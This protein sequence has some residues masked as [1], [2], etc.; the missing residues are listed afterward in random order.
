MANADEDNQDDI[1]YAEYNNDD[2]YVNNNNNN[3]DDYNSNSHHYY[4]YTNK[5]NNHY[6]YTVK[7]A[8]LG[9]PFYSFQD[10]LPEFEGYEPATR[11]PGPGA[12]YVTIA[13][14]IALVALVPFCMAIR[15]RF[16][17]RRRPRRRLR[18]FSKGSGGG[19]KGSST[20]FR[21]TVTSPT[22][23]TPPQSQSTDGI[24]KNSSGLFV[25]DGA[26]TCSE[27][28]H[29]KTNEK[30]DDAATIEDD[31]VQDEFEVEIDD[32]TTIIMDDDD[33][34]AYSLTKEDRMGS[35]K[36]ASLSASHALQFLWWLQWKPK[37]NRQN[38]VQRA[39]QVVRSFAHPPSPPRT[40]PSSSKQKFSPPSEISQSPSGGSMSSR[41]VGIIQLPKLYD[42]DDDESDDKD[43]KIYAY[44]GS[45][46]DWE[47]EAN[48]EALSP[49]SSIV[50]FDRVQ[51][52]SSLVS[53]SV[54]SSRRP[55]T[56]DELKRNETGVSSNSP[57]SHRLHR[58]A[59][60][61]DCNVQHIG[62][63]VGGT[64]HGH[65]V[66]N[67]SQEQLQL[68]LQRIGS[69]SNIRGVSCVS[70]TASAAAAAA[71]AD[72][73]AD[74]GYIEMT[75]APPLSQ[76]REP[77]PTPTTPLATNSSKISKRLQLLPASGDES[78]FLEDGK[79]FVASSAP[80]SFRVVLLPQPASCYLPPPPPLYQ[81]KMKRTCRKRDSNENG[82]DPE[83]ADVES[84][85]NTCVG[86]DLCCGKRPWWRFLCSRR[87]RHKVA[88][89]A[90]WD[91]EMEGLLN[92][93]IPST[94]TVLLAHLLGLA[95]VAVLGRLF[96]TVELSAYY[97]V[98][99]VFTLSTM[100]MEGAQTSL[101]SLCS[102]AVAA[103]KHHLAGQMVQLAVVFYQILLIPFAY[104]GIAYLEEIVLWL[105]F[106]QAVVDSAYAYAQVG[107]LHEFLGPIDQ[108]LYYLL[109]V[110]GN[111]VY[112]TALGLISSATSLTCVLYLGLCHQDT[113]SLRDIGV[114]HLVL[115]CIFV[116]VNVVVIWW[117]GWLKGY[118]SGMVGSL[119]L[120]NGRAV[121]LFLKQ[122]IPLAL[123][124]IMTFGEWE[125]LFVFAGYMGP[126]EVAVWG[127]LGSVWEALE[128][129]GLASADAAEERVAYLL[130]SGQTKRARYCAH[131]SLFVSVVSAAV[132]ILP[133]AVFQQDVSRW[134]TNDETLQRLFGEL[135]P[136]V[137]AGYV[138][139]VFGSMSWTLLG[140]Q[141][142]SGLA[143]AM[144]FVGSW[145]VA[146]PLSVLS[147][148]VLGYDLKGLASSVMIG[149]A[150]SGALNTYFL[151]QSNWE[152]LARRIQKRSE[153][154]QVKWY[155]Q[156][157]TTNKERSTRYNEATL[158]VRFDDLD[159]N[160]LPKYAQTAALK[161]GFD[162]KLWNTD[163]DPVALRTH[164]WEQLEAEQRQAALLLGLVPQEWNRKRRK[165]QQSQ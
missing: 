50:A 3:N 47:A 88:K 118:W 40:V 85:T 48:S 39:A 125:V 11:D 74:G 99:L 153:Q 32:S 56:A 37:R 109:E 121:R 66:G 164:S 25:P 46:F 145:G 12:F 97:S 123:G 106:D 131:K 54:T 9:D 142:R 15:E 62:A 150:C 87:F 122:A 29:K 82:G 83:V 57:G 42:D 52:S 139:M 154:E 75:L 95:E 133:V 149:Y 44:E 138:T 4:Y 111:E 16:R 49:S 94:F 86:I 165:Q 116:V 21:R 61:G 127:L 1:E 65:L 120:T 124:Y 152:K 135:I 13:L 78:I 143:T 162:S 26:A 81:E 147:T 137:C 35:R 68:R 8:D 24:M 161:L 67:N 34:S 38:R 126:A 70:N 23:T 20:I 45:T 104:V 144:G 100:I 79:D 17:P 64:P 146:L 113:A 73:V 130:G 115:E 53:L 102:H 134:F 114:I 112:A 155:N 18:R 103:G 110:T 69:S 55:T 10:D 7:K 27:P 96:G 59:S 119:A 91:S 132:C 58:S 136:Y 51:S 158:D 6:Y 76:L 80:T 63:G 89:C 108:G 141:D 43:S 41:F 140:A 159:W 117:N 92:S 28:I 151:M 98:E 156:S 19:L 128:E 60:D 33:A 77:P 30:I 129:I 93:A 5:T 105:G 36:N 90:S 22:T 71:A 84:L 107:F 163:H 148:M 101:Y 72:V 31:T 2:L 14:S 157:S 160:Q